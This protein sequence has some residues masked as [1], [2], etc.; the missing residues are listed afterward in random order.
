MLGAKHLQHQHTLTLSLCLPGDR[1]RGHPPRILKEGVRAFVPKGIH[2]M[3]RQRSPSPRY[4]PD[5]VPGVEHQ[6][7]P[8][9]GRVLEGLRAGR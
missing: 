6:P 3:V 1:P 9:Q 4:V 2:E 7:C 5:T 8:G